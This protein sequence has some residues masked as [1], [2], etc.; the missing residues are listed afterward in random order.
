[1]NTHINNKIIQW[2][3]FLALVML[4]PTYVWLIAGH[5][6]LPIWTMV[7]GVLEL[8]EYPAALI[9]LLMQISFYCL[10]FFLFAKNVSSLI[11]R[12]NAKFVSYL[13]LFTIIATL[14][15]F[16]TMPIYS[17]DSSHGTNNW[18]IYGVFAW[19]LR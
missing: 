9:I 18:N 7:L 17:T 8:Y 13:V 10:I 16:S 15:F 14:I 2:L 19:S 4:C 1:M 3:I 6:I 11:M 12:F 5:F